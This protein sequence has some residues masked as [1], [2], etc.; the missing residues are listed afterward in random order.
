MLSLVMLSVGSFIWL[1]T[2]VMPI[3]LLTDM[4]QGLGVSSGKA[5]LLVTGYAWVVAL[6]AIPLT[7]LTSGIDRRIMIAS[8][9]ALAGVVNILSAFVSNFA[10]MA[11]LRITLAFGHGVFWSTVAGVAVRLAPQMPVAKAAAWVFTGV[12]MGFAVGVPLISALSQWLGW[13]AAF[14]LCGLAALA[15]FAGLL[16]MLPPLPSQRRH[17][18][19]RPLLKQPVFLYIA[20]L[21][22]L[23][24]MAHFTAYTYVVPLLLAITHSPLTLIPTLLLAYGIAGIAGN[25]LSGRA[26]WGA[27]AIIIIAV[28]GLIFAYSLILLCGPSPLMV[29]VNMVLWGMAASALNMAPQSY[30][31][32]LA[33]HEREAACS[34]SVTGFNAGVGAGA[35]LGGVAV[36]TTGP[37]SLPLWGLA[38]AGL[39]LGVLYYGKRFTTQPILPVKE[40]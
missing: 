40:I 12:A 23:L 14:A 15:V 6:T 25:W 39:A 4:A 2:E 19:L 7:A 24:V 37:H 28:F 31:M 3:G 9:L 33:P 17:F 34:F 32:E 26:P 36:S 5:G 27:Y 20:G 11:L 21:T 8:L 13:R 29:W 18:D 30:A 22:M 35:L 1:V 16:F 38:L 10:V